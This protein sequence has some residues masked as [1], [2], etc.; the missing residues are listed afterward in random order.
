[1]NFSTMPP[2]RAINAFDVSK[3]LASSSRTSSASR[4]SDSL[5]NPTRSAKRTET[6]R[7]SKLGAVRVGSRC[8]TV[9]ALVVPVGEAVAASGEPH[10]PQNF[11]PGSFVVP[12]L[13]Q[14][15]ASGAPHSPQNFRWAAL[16]VPQVVQGSSS[17]LVG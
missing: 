5:V 8:A 3:Y 11:E 6:S 15:A 4:V 17:L 12:H 2:Y 13:G 1:M 10:S 16:S 9:S 7:R 14:A